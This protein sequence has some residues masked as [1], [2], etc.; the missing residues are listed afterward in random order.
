MSDLRENNYPYQAAGRIWIVPEIRLDAM[1]DGS[2]VIALDELDRIHRDIANEVCGSSERLT[3][4]ELEF[5]A[6]ITVTSFADIA[7]HLDL[8]RSTISKWRSMGTLPSGLVSRSLKRW[9]WVHLFASDLSFDSVP[10][11]LA[12]DDAEF[13]EFAHKIAISDGLAEPIM[14]KVA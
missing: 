1:P 9:F 13:L 8:N 10:I 2:V 3:Y 14:K 5:L 6:D 7:D 12:G 4:D 11:K